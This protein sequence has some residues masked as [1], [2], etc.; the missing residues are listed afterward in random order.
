MTGCGVSFRFEKIE[1]ACG[2]IVKLNFKNVQDITA[3]IILTK[4]SCA[5]FI[6][7]LF[8]TDII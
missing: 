7:K 5:N 2:K 4:N 1:L 3:L 8:T 6:S